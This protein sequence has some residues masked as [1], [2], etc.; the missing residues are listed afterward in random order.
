MGGISGVGILCEFAW[1]A[2][3]RGAEGRVATGCKDEAFVVTHFVGPK[4]YFF[5]GTVPFL[6]AR[7]NRR[8]LAGLLYYFQKH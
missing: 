6:I 3:D 1:L 4:V 8:T 2:D 5:Q 7:W